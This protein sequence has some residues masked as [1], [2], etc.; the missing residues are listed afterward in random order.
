V[1]GPFASATDG[2]ILRAVRRPAPLFALGL[3]VGLD[4][5]GAAI[6][7][8]FVLEREIG[9]WSYRRY[10]EVLDVEVAIEGNP[11]RGH[12]ATYI[13]RP[14][15]RQDPVPY[16]NVFVAVYERPTGLAAEVRRQV[17]ELATYDSEVVDRGGGRHWRLDGGP[18]DRWAMWVS[19]NRVVKIGVSEL[20]EEVPEP[21]LGAYFDLYPSDLDEFGR[22]REGTPS[23]GE[24]G[25]DDAI[26]SAEEGPAPELP[27]GVRG[28]GAR[29][30]A[31]ELG[32]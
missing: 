6:P 8:R 25:D 2:A 20:L 21:I 1:D 29:D 3:L 22:A 28:D 18:G 14:R 7:P 11:A 12:T 17:R 19:S 32:R 24:P 30:D 13:R 26:P 4:A 16:V 23:A 27:E 9:D 31:G 10:Q 5:C 15:R